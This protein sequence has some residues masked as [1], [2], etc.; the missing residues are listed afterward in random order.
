MP[1]RLAPP[2][3]VNHISQRD[4]ADLPEPAY[5][6]ADVGGIA[7][8]IVHAEWQRMLSRTQDEQKGG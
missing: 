8:S 2:T 5:R 1:V 4:A 6:V 3:F 7:V